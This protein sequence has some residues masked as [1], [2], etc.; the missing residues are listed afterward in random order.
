MAVNDVS[1]ANK[2]L[3]LI[4]ANTIAE[5]AGTTSEQIAATNLYEMMVEASLTMHR[6]RF[7][8]GQQQLNRDNDAPIDKWDASY[9]MPVDPPILLL[10]G[11]F[12]LDNPITY[13]RYESKIYTNTAATDVVIADYIYRA[14][15]QEWPPFFT[16]AVVY[17][18]AGAFAAAVTQDA[19]MA[20]L[21]IDLSVIEYRKA[22]FADSSSQTARHLR[23]DSLLK[24]R[25]A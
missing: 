23:A 2:A 3:T 4:G 19:A 14:I 10:N 12:V 24:R 25:L 11:V 9:Q 5:F 16:K 21:F 20:S 13:D 17:D 22:K 8:S 15:E 6:W 7:A 1:I 18:L